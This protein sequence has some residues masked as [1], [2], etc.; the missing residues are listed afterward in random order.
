[1]KQFMDENFLLGTETA[2]RLYHEVA[3]GLP[4]LDYHCHLSPREIWED[5]RFANLTELWLGGDHYKWRLMRAMGVE[6][7]Y[8]TGDA[9][10]REKFQKWAETL[11]LAVG[12][13]LYHWSHLELRRCFGYGGLLN[14]ETAQ[15]VWDLCNA[16]LAR[17]D[18]SARGLIRSAGGEALCTTDDPADSLEWHEKL[19]GSDFEVKVLPAFRPDLA[20]SPERPDYP[21]YL[22]RLGQAAGMEIDSYEALGA[23][24][25]KRVDFFHDHGCRISDHGM[26]AV[27]YAPATEL[28]LRILFEKRLRGE[29]LRSDELAQFKTGLLL[30][31]G[32]AYAAR[33]WVM[34]LHYGVIRNNSWRL[35]RALGPDCGLDS[36]GDR[37]SVAR[38]AAFLN[39]LDET[40][41]LPKT[42]LYS[43][44]PNDNAAIETVMGCFQGG[45]VRG[46]LQHGSAWWFNDHRD[47]MRAQLR[48]LAAEGMLA[49]FVGMLTDSRSFLS[50]ARHD[51]FR[52]VLCELL[53][54]WVERGEFPDD[55]ATLRSIVEGV[56]CRNAEAYFGL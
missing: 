52:R 47:G 37:G 18:F 19:A 4:I 43:L 27:P 1:M 55:Q 16:A 17:P 7:R 26:D 13:P 12:S 24:L 3:E 50:Y 39:A 8:I 54:E 20:L 10:A 48:S 38:L 45:G 5:R 28:N 42:I 25:L 31:L 53:G 30:L 44:D 15:E 41:E 49:T 46:K 22:R 35:F 6:E 21:D 14:G 56:C 36:I 29:A 23:A 9:P 33:G 34:Q 32:R 40:D 51:Y 11:A 2:R